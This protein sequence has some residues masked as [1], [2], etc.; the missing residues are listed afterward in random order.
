M[1]KLYRLTLTVLT[2]F[3]FTNPLSAKELLALSNLVHQAA[4]VT[5]E[6]YPDS[7]D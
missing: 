5:A 4:L 1:K 6:N 2:F 7:D 3:L